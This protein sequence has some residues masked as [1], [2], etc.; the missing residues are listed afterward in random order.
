M[1]FLTAPLLWNAVSWP[2]RKSADLRERAHGDGM[3]VGYDSPE[4][5]EEVL[6]RSAWATKYKSDRILLWADNDDGSAFHQDFLNHIRKILS[7]RVPHGQDARYASKNNANIARLGLLTGLFPDGIILVPFRDPVGQAASLLQQ[8]TRF[9]ALHKTDSFAR[10]YMDDI[11]HLEFGEL[12]RPICF[13]GMEDVRARYRPDTLAYWV[14]YWECAFRH[15]LTHHSSVTLMS[16]ESLCARGSA[17]ARGL[18]SRLSLPVDTL[19]R[20]LGNRMRPPN[21][22]TSDAEVREPALVERCRALHAELLSRCVLA[23]SAGVQ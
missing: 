1:P 19:T 13:E 15:V 7:L 21:D 6:W 14:A 5:F 8:H 2:F 18:A 23:D 20:A 9:R 3:E 16:Y 4:A 12:H 22:R 17:A 10:Q 11:G